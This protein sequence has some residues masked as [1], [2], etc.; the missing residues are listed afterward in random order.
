MIVDVAAAW[1]ANA[2]TN[3]E[4]EIALAAGWFTPAGGSG[5]ATLNVALIDKS[6]T[7]NQA[8]LVQQLPAISIAPCSQTGCATGNVGKVT[9]KVGGTAGAETLSFKYSPGENQSCMLPMIMRRYTVASPSDF[10]YTAKEPCFPV[11]VPK[12]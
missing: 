8:K 2:L 5:P 11:T 10:V 3:N 7:W 9:V 4:G 12:I 6:S 1:A